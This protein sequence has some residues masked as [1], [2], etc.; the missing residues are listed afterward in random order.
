M[1]EEVAINVVIPSSFA[2]DIQGNFHRGLMLG[3][4]VGFVLGVAAV[5]AGALA[6]LAIVR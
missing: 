5:A 4:L 1:T 2:L 3:V 6:F